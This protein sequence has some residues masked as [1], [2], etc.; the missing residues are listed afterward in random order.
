MNQ[1]EQ[2]S[3][4]SCSIT[5]I[6]KYLI[7]CRLE[8]RNG[9]EL[10]SVLLQNLSKTPIDLAQIEKISYNKTQ[11]KG[12]LIMW[13]T[14]QVLIFCLFACQIGMLLL[15]V[16]YLRRRTLSGI[17]YLLWGLLALFL[18]LIGPYLVIAARPGEL[19]RDIQG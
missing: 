18:P 17:A 16:F 2:Q 8:P 5:I 1:W 14:P 11:N 13:I 9:K 15:A 4:H 10:F 6:E 12:S 19:V 3:N 7:R